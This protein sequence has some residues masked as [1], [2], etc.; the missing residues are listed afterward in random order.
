MQSLSPEE[1]ARY[2]RQIILPEIGPTGQ[3]KLKKA[4]V[5]ISGLGGLGSVIAYYVVA[6]GVGYVRLVDRDEVEMDNLNRQI[7]HWTDDIGKNKTDSAIDKLKRLNPN[8]ELDAFFE[9]VREDNI[10]DLI[11]DCR[12]IADGTDNLETRRIL[13]IASVMK[14]IPFVLGGVEGFNGMT[15]TFVP[16]ETPCLECLFPHQE[17]ANKA[18]GVLGP[19]PGLVASIQVLEIIKLI[20]NIET[21][22]KG[23]LLHIRGTD[24]TFKSIKVER[25]PDC[26]ICGPIRPRGPAE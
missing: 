10:I 6:A 23:R 13:N 5:F 24:M 4:K 17:S 11:G 8:C 19:V 21:L 14:G 18:M 20:L 12:Y 1:Y 25:N 15:T 16:N 9:E 26:E 3:D 2:N 7:L 22:L